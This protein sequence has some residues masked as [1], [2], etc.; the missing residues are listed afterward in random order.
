MIDVAFAYTRGLP[1]F[2]GFFAYN[3]DDDDDTRNLSPYGRVIPPWPRV[4]HL[5]M[6]VLLTNVSCHAFIGD[7]RFGW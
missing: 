5:L 6:I 7:N 1:D 3:D 2:V 4:C